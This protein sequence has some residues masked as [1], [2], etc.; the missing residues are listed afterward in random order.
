MSIAYWCVLV[1][2]VLPYVWTGLAKSR[3][4]RYDNR[5][6]RAWFAKQTDHAVQRAHA[7]HL[8]AF[9]AFP[10]FAAGV[11]AC[12][13]TDVPAVTVNAL[14]VVFVVARVLHGA[15]YVSGHALARSVVWIVGIGCALGLLVQAALAA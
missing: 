5:N 7:A 8:N 15:L 6:P 11:L 9:E 1:T 3:G 2:A 4:Q 13:L 14:A 10:V 12:D